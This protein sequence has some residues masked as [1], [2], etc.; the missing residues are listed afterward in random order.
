MAPIE[1]AD[2][3]T[4]QY[5]QGFDPQYN[6]RVRFAGKA[7]NGLFEFGGA[8]VHQL[9]GFGREHE[10]GE[11]KLPFR[12]GLCEDMSWDRYVGRRACL[13]YVTKQEFRSRSRLHDLP[14]RSAG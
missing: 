1:T 11:A 3:S 6:D 2:V 4:E 13:G 12:I 7:S 9:L 8:S 5:V 10:G 14:A